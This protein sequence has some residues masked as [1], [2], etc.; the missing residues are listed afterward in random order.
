MKFAPG[1]LAL[2]IVA[3][4]GPDERRGVGNDAAVVVDVDANV[5][6]DICTQQGKPLTTISGTVYAPNGTLQVYG[7]NVYIPAAD[8]GPLAEGL[9]CSKCVDELPGG[10][11]AATTSGT[12]GEFTLTNVPT[13]V[14]I[15]LV[16]QVG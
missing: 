8:P 6:P 9:Q 4:C 2:L 3:A 10:S 16:I 1:L 15:A 12:F 7:A 11:L 14:N 5:P 13:G